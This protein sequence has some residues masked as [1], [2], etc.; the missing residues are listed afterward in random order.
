MPTI[1]AATIDDWPAIATLLAEASLPLAGAEEHLSS[2]LVAERDGKIIA[3]AALERHGDDGLVRSVAVHSSARGQKIGDQLVRALLSSGRGLKSVSLL[4]T[5][6]DTWFPRFGF[7]RVDRASLPAA[8]NDSAELRGA[9][10]A[11]AV[12][13]MLR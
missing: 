6:A 9:C 1:R 11:S 2:F 10:P 8:L 12:A 7:Q 4:T 5:T 13:M 3:C